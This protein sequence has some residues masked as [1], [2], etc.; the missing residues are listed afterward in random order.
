MQQ[1]TNAVKRV[2]ARWAQDE[3]PPGYEGT[4]SFDGNRLGFIDDGYTRA[5][6]AHNEQLEQDSQWQPIV[7]LGDK[8]KRR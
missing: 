6:K 8:P 1:L 5:S 3:T 2:L 4:V 7:V